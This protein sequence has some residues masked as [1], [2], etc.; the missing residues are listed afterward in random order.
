MFSKGRTHLAQPPPSSL[1]KELECIRYCIFLLQFLPITFRRGQA[2]ILTDFP[3]QPRKNFLADRKQ[4]VEKFAILEARLFCLRW[5]YGHLFIDWMSAVLFPFICTCC[6]LLKAYFGKLVRFLGG[7]WSIIS[8]VQRVRDLV[9]SS[10]AAER[11]MFF[12]TLSGTWICGQQVMMTG[13]W[14]S[15]WKKL[16][17]PC[18]QEMSAVNRVTLTFAS[19]VKQAL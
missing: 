14:S 10:F 15:G 18:I 7:T 16:V 9:R 8:I 6:F 3:F 4:Q 2:L 5:R 13:E 19:S 12:C 17:H 1:T 11:G